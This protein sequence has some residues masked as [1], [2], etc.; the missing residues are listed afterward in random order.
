VTHLGRS[1]LQ[2]EGVFG[3]DG[4]GPYFVWGDFGDCRIHIFSPRDWVFL[5]TEGLDTGPCWF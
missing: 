5:V 3:W 1:S 2:S 4:Q